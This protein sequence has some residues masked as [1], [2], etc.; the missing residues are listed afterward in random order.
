MFP[1]HLCG[2]QC[3]PSGRINYNFGMKSL[4]TVISIRSYTDYASIFCDDVSDCD[5]M[6][7]RDTFRGGIV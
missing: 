2:Q 5:T 6:A 3:V 1:V 7:D 4:W